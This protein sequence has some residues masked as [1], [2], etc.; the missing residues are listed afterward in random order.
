MEGAGKAPVQPADSLVPRVVLPSPH[1]VSNHHHPGTGLDDKLLLSAGSRREEGLGKPVPLLSPRPA[2]TAREP[3][4]WAPQD[5]RG[6]LTTPQ[7]AVLLFVCLVTLGQDWVCPLQA[8]GRC[9]E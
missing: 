6:H 7:D 9:V 3:L 5:G 1:L 8:A 4:L 2:G